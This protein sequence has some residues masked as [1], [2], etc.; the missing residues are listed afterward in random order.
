MGVRTGPNVCAGTAGARGGRQLIDVSEVRV[1][2][3]DGI[4]ILH[5]PKAGRTIAS[6][7]FRV[8]RFDETLP[9]SGITHLVEHLAIRE[10]GSPPL[11][12]NGQ[13]E[14]RFTRF[15]GATSDPGILGD[16]LGSLCRSLGRLNVEPLEQERRILLTEEAGRASGAWGTALSERFG[17]T[18]PGLVG[19]PEYGLR[20]RTAGAVLQWSRDHFVAQNAI[21]CVVGTLPERLNLELPTGARSRSPDPHARRFELPA[22]LVTDTTR[23]A[24]TFLGRRQTESVVALDAFEQRLRRRLRHEMGLSYEIQRIQDHVGPSVTHTLLAPSSLP[25]NLPAV[26]HAML[27]VTDDI[28]SAGPTEE[29]KAD[30]IRRVADF[31]ASDQAQVIHL[32]Q[33]A[34]EILDGR[35]PIEPERLLDEVREMSSATAAEAFGELNASALVAVP[36]PIPAVTGRMPSAPRFSP[37][38]VDGELKVKA[39]NFRRWPELIQGDQGVSL[40]GKDGS[41][42]TVRYDQCAAMVRWSDGQI[43]LISEDG[44]LVHLNP[45]EWKDGSGIVRALEAHVDS[46]L[47]VSIDHPGPQKPAEATPKSAK[48]K[49]TPAAVFVSRLRLLRLIFIVA[50]IAGVNLV[51]THSADAAFWVGAA[52]VVLGVGAMVAQYAYVK[53]LARRRRGG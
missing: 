29:E 39:E 48:R 49:P 2:E 27:T 31:Y 3:V 8:G 52:L 16:F 51:T 5:W 11:E 17:A 28:A 25:E 1:L 53:R 21:L 34:Q 38:K 45:Q 32:D 9:T 24:I 13:V 10:L 7:L 19:Y 18:G 36:R 40:V 46:G 20:S 50:A 30:F 41:Y 33:R 15:W 4:P 14:G 47:V 35:T 12:L 22:Y 44:F 6:F 37:D 42:A 43:R 26:T 23:P